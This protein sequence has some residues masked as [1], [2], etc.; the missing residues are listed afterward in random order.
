MRREMADGVRMAGWE[1]GIGFEMK[2]VI[3]NEIGT[4]VNFGC[5]G[6]ERERR[7]ESHLWRG[8][9]YQC[10]KIWASWD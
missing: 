10:T 3:V 1:L 2:D 5:F 4:G 7:R 8:Y 9:W 6:V